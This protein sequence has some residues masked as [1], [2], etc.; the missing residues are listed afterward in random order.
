MAYYAG[1]RATELS[2]L[3]HQAGTPW[4]LVRQEMAVSAN[5]GGIIDNQLIRQSF[6]K[7]DIAWLASAEIKFRPSALT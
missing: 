4:K 5:F 6:S 3:T 1:F 7:M 2:D